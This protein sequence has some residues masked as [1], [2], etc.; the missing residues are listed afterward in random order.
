M[1]S[2]EHGQRIRQTC[3]PN[4]IKINTILK[5]T[6]QIRQVCDNSLKQVFIKF[7]RQRTRDSNG[8]N[9]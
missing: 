5:T 6:N 2:L 1:E 7:T 3:L 9:D 4:L 8:T